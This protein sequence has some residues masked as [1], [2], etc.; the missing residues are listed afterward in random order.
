MALDRTR[1]K[2][3]LIYVA[4]ENRCVAMISV[5][6]DHMSE[7]LALAIY[8]PEPL[9]SESSPLPPAVYFLWHYP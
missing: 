2:R 3:I 4:A 5:P 8:F 1:L 7:R 6:Y 9:T